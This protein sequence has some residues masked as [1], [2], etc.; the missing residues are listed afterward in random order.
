MRFQT[1]NTTTGFHASAVDLGRLKSELERAIVRFDME[2]VHARWGVDLGAWMTRLV[3]SWVQRAKELKFDLRER[4]VR[5]QIET[6]DDAGYYDYA[7][8]VMPGRKGG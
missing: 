1:S 5:V 2:T 7:F 4:G 3:F 8:D 6:Q